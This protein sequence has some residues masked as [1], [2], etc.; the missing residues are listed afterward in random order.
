MPPNKYY[1]TL[2]D[3]V[4]NGKEPT[5]GMEYI[6]VNDLPKTILKN[7]KRIDTMLHQ[8]TV[9][10]DV[11]RKTTS[12]GQPDG[13][14][15]TIKET[16]VKMHT[17]YPSALAENT[18]ENLAKLEEYHKLQKERDK[19]TKILHEKFNQLDTLAIKEE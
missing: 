4:D 1:E 2:Q 19:L 17:N 3:L 15:F 12:R 14:T 9:V 8:D 10:T 6:I 7:G 13:Y 11:V 5:P 18:P 16:G